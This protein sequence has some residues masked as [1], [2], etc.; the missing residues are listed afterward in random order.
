MYVISCTPP[1]PLHPPSPLPPLS[2]SLVQF[3]LKLSIYYYWDWTLLVPGL[4]HDL[5]SYP[6]TL[7]LPPILQNTSIALEHLTCWMRRSNVLPWC[8]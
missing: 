2:E 3:E 5:W 1:P 4:T 6:A 7:L 8:T